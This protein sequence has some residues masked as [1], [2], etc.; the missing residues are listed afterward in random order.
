LKRKEK[1][2]RREGEGRGGERGGEGRGG[3]ERGGEER[4]L[5][6][7]CKA[8]CCYHASLSAVKVLFLH[9]GTPL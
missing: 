2:K 5:E 7:G 4:R 1:E 3:E 9:Q 6:K 8:E